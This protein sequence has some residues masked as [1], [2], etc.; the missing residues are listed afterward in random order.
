MSTKRI[1]IAPDDPSALP[2]GRIDPARVDAT[3]EAEIA[4]RERE[5]EEEAKQ[6]E[7]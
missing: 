4:A 1:K 6:D 3:T 2:A 7:V 5:D